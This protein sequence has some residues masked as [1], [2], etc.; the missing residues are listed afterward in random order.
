MSGPDRPVIL[1]QRKLRLLPLFFASHAFKL[2]VDCN[3]LAQCQDVASV[4]AEL[5]LELCLIYSSQVELH[6]S[7]GS[8][9]PC[10]GGDLAL[11]R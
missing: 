5:Q 11:R 7:R 3:K 1:A 9:N 2:A 4:H 10:A 8:F 6:A